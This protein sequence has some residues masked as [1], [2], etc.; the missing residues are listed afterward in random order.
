MH[1]EEQKF[2]QEAANGHDYFRKA[3]GFHETW[4]ALFDHKIAG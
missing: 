1:G 2:I 3:D 4:T